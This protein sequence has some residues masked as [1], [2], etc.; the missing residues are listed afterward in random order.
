MAEITQRAKD[1][2]QRFSQLR[3]SRGTWEGYWRET[4]QYTYPDYDDFW[5]DR[6]NSSRGEKKNQRIFDATAP[7]ALSQFG[8]L[9]ESLLIPRNQRWH[10]I[11]FTQ[12]TVNSS[13]DVREWSEQVTDI[14]F[15]LRYAPNAN[16]QMQMAEAF[17]S[18]GCFGNGV[19]FVDDIAGGGFRYRARFIGDT[20][21]DVN[22]QGLI[23]TVYLRFDYTHRQ[24]VQR[25]GDDCPEQIRKLAESDPHASSSYLHVVLPNPDPVAGR[26]DAAGMP[27]SSLIISLQ[28]GEECEFGGYRSMRFAVGRY[29]TSPHELYGRGPAMSVLPDIRTLNEM[30]RADLRATH[31]LVDPPLLV[32][33]D[34]VLGAGQQDILLDPGMINFGGV[35]ADGRPLIQPLQTNARVDI[36]EAK[37]EVKRNTIREAFLVNTFQI[38][39]Q[40]PRMTA[41]EAM[42][43]AQEKGAL[44]GPIMGRL[45]TE[46]LGPIIQAELEIASSAGLLPDPPAAAVAA[47][48]GGQYEFTYDSPLS[49]MQKSEQLV[50][51]DMLI[52]Q[53]VALANIGQQ[54][55]LDSIDGNAVMRVTQEIGGAPFSTVRTAEQVAAIAQQRAAQE[56]QAQQVEQGSQ[57]A[58]AVKDL[59]QAEKFQGETI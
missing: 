52:Q 6:Q 8:S 24:A 28:T 45:Q 44:L 37:M 16:F 5:Q 51:V 30:A 14:L 56:Q 59:A 54:G 41:T 34:G 20:Y 38:L 55:A 10:G 4:A 31:K 29:Q 2:K 58:G 50:G 35:N 25:W 39:V 7:H 3:D 9:L 53:A 22:W 36:N 23:D 26:E 32:H 46:L 13:R 27:F 48:A 12:P 15:Q 47:L 40:T 18:I 11:Q 49:R 19:V 42:M 1:A 43:R 57:M 21:F 17:L 33:D